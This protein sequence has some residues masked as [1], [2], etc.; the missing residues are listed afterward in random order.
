MSFKNFIIV[1]ILFHLVL[2]AG[3]L[4]SLKRAK[5]PLEQQPLIAR[6]ITPR[7]LLSLPRPKPMP[8]PPAA[9]K[10]PAP[11][12]PHV[13]QK[14][15]PPPPPPV[16]AP[17][18]RPNEPPPKVKSAVPSSPHP[19]TLPRPQLEPQTRAH[20]GVLN[21][22]APGSSAGAAPNQEAAKAENKYGLEAAGKGRN[23]IVPK[24][25][26][27]AMRKE[28]EQVE[29][30]EIA[31][32]DIKKPG[33]SAITFSTKE[34]KYYGYMQR[35]KEK[36]ESIWMYP[37]YAAQKGLYGEL[38][39]DFTIRPDGSLGAVELKRT[40]GYQILDDAAMKALKDAQPFWP[41]PKK[42]GKDGF[43]VEGHF[44]YTLG[45]SYLR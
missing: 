18:I 43:T 33:E 6:L 37:S 13:I 22:K 16:R 11:P 5:T 31:R 14:Q 2:F 17:K 3:L 9:K 44:V 28:L 15:L 21:P 23:K 36:I 38:V 10:F 45:G 7:E 40:S 8:V 25:G 32:A 12:R 27:G 29:K 42:W 41:L 4:I 24:F 30:Q 34:F 39:I 35:L 19:K 26:L 1:S 20:E